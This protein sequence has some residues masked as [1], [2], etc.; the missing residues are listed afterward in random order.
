MHS[1]VN[2]TSLGTLLGMLSELTFDKLIM[3]DS[4]SNWLKESSGLSN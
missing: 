1:G 2:V 4:M 3:I